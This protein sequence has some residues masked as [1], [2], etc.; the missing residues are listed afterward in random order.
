M[1]TAVVCKERIKKSNKRKKKT[2][3]GAIKTLRNQPLLPFSYHSEE[4]KKI[5]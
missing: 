5:I 4:G 2:K 3:G 1:K